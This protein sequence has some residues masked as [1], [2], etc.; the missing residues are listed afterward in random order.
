M[1][2][3]VAFIGLASVAMLNPTRLVSS[4]YFTGG[5]GVIAFTA[6]A[7][8]LGSANVRRFYVS[9]SIACSIYLFVSIGGGLGSNSP[10]LLTQVLFYEIDGIFPPHYH[11]LQ[12]PTIALG[13]TP[14][15][16]QKPEFQTEDMLI[17]WHVVWSIVLGEIAGL[18]SAHLCRQPKIAG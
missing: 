9:F 8:I 4:L 2:L 16:T 11:G 3:Y 10:L 12:P 15:A 7:S 5:V 18:L 13:G 1:L 17:I 6:V 14:P